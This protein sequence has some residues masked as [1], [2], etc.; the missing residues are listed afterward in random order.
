VAQL[1]WEH[2]ITR[3]LEDA[4]GSLHYMEITDRIV[5]GQLRKSLGATP[6]ATVASV[7]STTLK[8]DGASAPWVRIGRGAYAL[9]RQS[10]GGAAPI[11]DIDPVEADV[12]EQ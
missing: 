3:V 11:L 7:L 12:D 5:S 8:R 9:T 4:G 1:T 6:A 2:A 10:E